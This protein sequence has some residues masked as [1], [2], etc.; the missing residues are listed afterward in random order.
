[1][2]EQPYPPLRTLDDVLVRAAFR[3]Q[4]SGM[5]LENSMYGRGVPLE[6]LHAYA[7]REPISRA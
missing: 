3:A 1:M 5:M 2:W 4:V 7:P 6:A